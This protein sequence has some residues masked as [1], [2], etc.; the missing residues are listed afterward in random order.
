VP[1]WATGPDSARARRTNRA[2]AVTLF[3]RSP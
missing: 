3:T 1:A 2:K